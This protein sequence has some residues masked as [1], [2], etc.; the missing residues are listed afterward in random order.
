[1][2]REGHDEHEGR[3]EGGLWRLR[4]ASPLP[5]R[6]ERVVSDV[7]GCALAVHR[8]LGP[9]FLESIYQRAMCIELTARGLAFETERGVAVEYRGVPIPG[10]RI[11]LIVESAVVVELKC[12][13]GFEPIH[14]QQVVS[15]LKTTGLRVGLLINFKVERLQYGLKRIVA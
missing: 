5:A 10:Q 1:M 6:T 4:V 13:D 9:G 11:D 7:I 15:Y 12:L 8:A 2:T 14:I 3:H